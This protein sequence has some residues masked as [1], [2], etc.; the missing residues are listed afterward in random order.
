MFFGAIKL[1]AIAGFPIVMVVAAVSDFLRYTVPNWLSVV[2]LA[3]FG[4]VAFANSMKLSVAVEH[5]AVGAAI[6]LVGWLL[7]LIRAMGGA[8]V[9]LMAAGAV[10]FGPPLVMRF[11]LITFLI[12]GV[13]TAAILLFRR[14]PLLDAM[15]RRSGTRKLHDREQGIPFCVAIGAGALSVF[16]EIPIVIAAASFSAFSA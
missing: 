5:L 6:L 10:W 7:F 12:G 15:L 4:A 9:K 11:L 14:L 2:L 3:L 16:P 1:A 8:D 13:L